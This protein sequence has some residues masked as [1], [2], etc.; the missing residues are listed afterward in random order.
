MSNFIIGISGITLSPL[1]IVPIKNRNFL[2]RIIFI[3][4][5]GNSIVFIHIGVILVG[6]SIVNSTVFVLT[7]V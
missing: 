3:I 5:I 1:E 4:R 2:K 6:N 7:N